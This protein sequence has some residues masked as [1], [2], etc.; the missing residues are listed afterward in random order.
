VNQLQPATPLVPATQLRTARDQLDR[1]LT[2]SR[3]ATRFYAAAL[4]L[5]TIGAGA[6]VGYAFIR[7]RV[8]KSETLIL[9]REGIR[10]T[11]L[12][13]GEDTGDRA[14]KLGLRLKEMV[15]SRTQLE[16]IVKQAGLYPEL[17]EERGLIDAV[18]EMRKHIAFRVQD[19][20]TFGLSFEGDNPKMVQQVTER[21][22]D[23][24]LAENS[25]THA[26][27]A[28][29][30]KEFL[31]REK[32][33]T[34]EELREKETALAQFL[35]KHP[36]FAKEST[37]GVG[38]NQAGTAIRAQ[39]AKTTAPKDPVLASLER[40]AQRLQERLGMPTAKKTATA[41]TGDPVLVQAK[42]DADADVRGAQRDLAEKTSQFTEEHPDV[43]AARAR[44]KVAQ[45][46]LKRASDALAANIAAAQ[47]KSV[48]KEEDEG[49]I[50]RGA[51]ENELHRINEEI[52]AYKAKKLKES[53]PSTGN[54][55]VALETDWTRLNR[56]VVDARERF[57]SLQDKQF[58]ASMV[59][60]AAASGRT[61]QMVVVDPAFFPTHAAK[62]GRTVIAAAGFAIS[63]A[64]AL[65]LAVM[66]AIVDDRL[67]DRVDVER[68]SLL[69]LVGVVP[70]ADKKRG[71][72]QSG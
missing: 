44:L 50:D 13:G 62:P 15:L 40:E 4:V 7:K 1:V 21:L 35:A 19:G 20:D 57:Q 23:A 32:K 8:F 55:V 27:Q 12:V 61:A 56:E 2:I 42:A 58:K 6:S 54:W 38:G 24:L 47:Q 16:M 70:R 9:Y 52:A 53:A 3:R 51:L 31:D 28:E 49:T 34:E 46:K 48:A 30:T 69:P 59:E 29:V 10:S 45:E 17:V 43:R 33:R 25:K 71:R 18:D 5:L 14:H 60:T 26:E 65:A 22:A 39:Q 64:L 41:F 67:Y 72:Q 37:Q 11:D 63:L 68:L 36:E 66:L